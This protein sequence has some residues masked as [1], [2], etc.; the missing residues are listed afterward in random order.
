MLLDDAYEINRNP[1][2][3][4][5]RVNYAEAEPLYPDFL[6]PRDLASFVGRAKQAPAGQT[7]AAHRR[8]RYARFLD[9]TNGPVFERDA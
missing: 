4:R 3:Y 7:D 6:T 2:A 5:M 9:E 8:A 1:V